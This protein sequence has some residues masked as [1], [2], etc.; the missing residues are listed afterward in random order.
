M[1]GISLEKLA[2]KINAQVISNLSELLSNISLDSI[3]AARSLYQYAAELEGGN[4][5]E[6]SYPYLR[7]VLQFKNV[8]L[9]EQ[10]NGNFADTIARSFYFDCFQFYFCL[11]YM[12]PLIAEYFFLVAL[13]KYCHSKL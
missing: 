10:P 3:G 12:M 13:L 8:L 9:V 4:K 11:S 5:T 2:E 1:N 7:D 6:D